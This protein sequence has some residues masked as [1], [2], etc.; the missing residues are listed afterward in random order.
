[1]FV[2]A[3]EHN[4][5]TVFTP[6][7]KPI[8]YMLCTWDLHFT[9]GLYSVISCYLVIQENTKYGGHH[10]SDVDDGDRIAQ[11]DEWHR[12]HSNALGAVSDS[13]AEWGDESYDRERYDILCKVAE[14]IDE[15]KRN[16]TRSVGAVSLH[17]ITQSQW[18]EECG[19][20]EP[21]H[22]HNETR[23]V[24]AVSLHTITQSIRVYFQ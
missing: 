11:C 7:R 13:V 16:E 18:D 5:Q 17:T 22:N 23:S 12:D 6:A 19:S 2:A 20:C 24:G 9:Q 4:I 1:M 21:A 8:G 15:Q 10:A 14:A 3:H